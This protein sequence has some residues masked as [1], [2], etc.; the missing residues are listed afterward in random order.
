MSQ[1]KTRTSSKAEAASATKD[2]CPVCD[3]FGAIT[4]D[5]PLE[6][7][8]FGKSFPCPKCGEETLREQQSNIS[9]A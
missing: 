4:Y 7:P 9:A 5:V 3:G 1:E 8:R 6:D 2:T